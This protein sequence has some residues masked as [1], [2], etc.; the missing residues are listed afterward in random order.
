M[1]PGVN[2]SIEA[3]FGG[4]TFFARSHPGELCGSNGLPLTPNSITIYGRAQYLKTIEHPHL[5]SYL[6]VIRGKHE[7]TVV[8]SEYHSE[9]LR[10]KKINV[11]DATRI[12]FQI[13][14][15]LEYLNSLHIVHRNLCPDNILFD[16]DENVQLFNYGLYYMTNRGSNVLF[17]IGWVCICIYLY[18]GLWLGLC[19][20]HRIFIIH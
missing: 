15:A 8:V 16:G 14:S 2:Q 20:L 3:Q 11:K 1:C 10:G 17:P 6:T 19:E 18:L 12:G 13:L 4:L 9:S 5:C 7:R